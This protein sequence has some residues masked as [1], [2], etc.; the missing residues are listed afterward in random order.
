MNANFI[1][2]I[3]CQRVMIRTGTT[4]GVPVE[5]LFASE[6]HFRLLLQQPQEPVNDL[7]IAPC[8]LLA[9]QRLY[10]LTCHLWAMV[11]WPC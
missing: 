11:L 10:L 4:G 5:N 2:R 3:V 7:T 1:M 6:D 9:G 8:R